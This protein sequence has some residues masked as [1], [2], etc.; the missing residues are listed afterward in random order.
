MW[1]PLKKQCVGTNGRSRNRLSTLVAALSVLLALVALVPVLVTCKRSAS[2]P[3][4]FHE[5]SRLTLALDLLP[6]L[7]LLRATA[8]LLRLRSIV[9]TILAGRLLALASSS[10]L[11][12]LGLAVAVAALQGLAGGFAGHRLEGS[13]LNFGAPLFGGGVPVDLHVVVSRCMCE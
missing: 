11:L 13:D 5:A 1:Y 3:D 6:R 12:R 8:T 4:R 10:G 9:G 2:N 7:G